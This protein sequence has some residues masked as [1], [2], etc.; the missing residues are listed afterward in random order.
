MKLQTKYNLLQILFWVSYC[1]IY[2]YITVFL[3][4]K[5][6]TN[7]EIGIVTGVGSI[8]TIFLSP[9]IS[10][11]ISKIKDLTIK[12]LL[13]ILYTFNIV[14]MLLFT[15]LPIPT[16]VIMILYMIIIAF[17]VS[18][19]PLVST[20]CMD[21]LKV[22]KYINFGVSRGMGSV[23]YATT[24]VVLGQLIEFL[25]PNACTYLFV[26]SSIFLFID[27]F[28]FEDIQIQD[29]NKNEE[30][31]SIIEVVKTYKV[32]FM[33]LLGFGFMFS[34][35]SAL[36]VYLINI[37]KN[38]GGSTSLYGVAV[39]AM[40][41]SELPFMSIVHTLLKKHKAESILFI[42]S[43]FYIFRNFTICLAGN[44]TILI[45]GMLFQGASYGL[46]TGV[47]TYYVNDYLKPE[48]Q[49]LG[50]TLIAMITTGF[51]STIGNVLGGFLQD[52]FGL[53]SM[54]YFAMGITIIAFIMI[55]ITLKIIKQPEKI[56]I[57]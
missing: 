12:K 9:F 52:S 29:S 34:A 18:A 49:V 4:Y 17:M 42:A 15:F 5:G 8:S 37:V 11:L 46:F 14:A 51:G 7:S 50:Q 21:Y 1:S 56:N 22:G 24:A 6:M 48:H 32:F 33:I 54:L 43:I 39:F 40:A 20:I 55:F 45:I 26:I 30:T 28:S 47:I 3:Q 27:L 36:S 44:T 2:G 38:L 23:A 25:N 35:T 57:E 53:Q 10:S 19:V 41:A 13:F 31:T 16:I